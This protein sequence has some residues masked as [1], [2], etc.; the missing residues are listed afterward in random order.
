MTE[1][2]P[3]LLMRA[4]MMAHLY[5]AK[6]QALVCSGGS[7]GE[8]AFR[9]SL[10]PQYTSARHDAKG[11]HTY[12]ITGT[13]G[14]VAISRISSGHIGRQVAGTSS[15]LLCIVVLSNTCFWEG[16]AFEGSQ[17]IVGLEVHAQRLTR[18]GPQ[19]ISNC[20]S[21]NNINLASLRHVEEIPED[22]LQNCTHLKELDLGPLSNVKTVERSFLCGCSSLT[23]V[24]LAPLKNINILPSAFMK[25]CTSLLEVDLTPFSN[26]TNIGDFFLSGCSSL[27]NIN[28]TPLQNV[29]VVRSAF[30][31][32]C[33]G[34]LE[35]DMSPLRHIKSVQNF[36]LSRCSSLK[37]VDL[38]P[39][40]NIT[41]VQEGFLSGCTAL[42]EV[43][44]TPICSAVEIDDS[45]FSECTNLSN[46]ILHLPL[47]DD[48]F[49]VSTSVAMEA[50]R[51]SAEVAA[52]V[53]K[54]VKDCKITLV[55]P[56]TSRGYVNDAQ[57]AVLIDAAKT[58]FEIS[59]V[60]TELQVCNLI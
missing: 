7:E 16:G 52:K 24:D 58:V 40:H 46:L 17:H 19:F 42:K 59:G 45:A 48:S 41:I 11:L 10:E 28:L 21:L 27:S 29:E 35:V 57:R 37:R 49:T 39:L 60:V 9:E 15:G 55:V 47:P 34:L 32:R 14:G 33:S 2:N 22:F 56:P 38:A 4:W 43:D 36:F 53:A 1:L 26:V 30:L 54:F 8:A 13:S 12:Y 18:I 31:Y 20:S 5:G 23:S 44:L 50:I 25:D 51:A 6:L 3:N